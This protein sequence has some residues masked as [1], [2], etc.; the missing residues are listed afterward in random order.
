MTRPFSSAALASRN[1]HVIPCADRSRP[2][3]VT[4]MADTHAFLRDLTLVLAVAAITTV[5]FQRLRQPVVLGYLLAGMIISPNTPIPLVADLET[6]HTLAE[7][8]VI[9]LMFS[10]GLEFSFR[11]LVRMGPRA[12]FVALIQS[13]LMVW[14]GF[15]VG[16]AFGW[17]PLESLF[18]GAAIAISSTTIIVKAFQEQGVKG[19]LASVVFAVLIV[20]DLIAILLLAV[21][22]AVA[23]GA[24]VSAGSLLTTLLQLVLFLLAMLVLGYLIVPRA[25]RF[26][27]RLERSE[28]ILV[29]CIGT[30]F[31]L[32]YIAQA[33]GYSVAL[34][35]FMAGSLMAESGEEKKIEHL[36]E[37]VRDMF[38][39]IFF[40][41]VGMLID[42]RLIAEH[43]AAVLALVG[44]VIV[45]KLVGVASGAFLAGYGTRT[46][47]EAGLSLAQ[48]GEF[49][50]IIASLGVSLGVVRPFLYPVA[51]A[52]SAVTT[53]TTPWLIRAAPRIATRLDHLL[54]QPLQTFAALYASWWERFGAA[55]KP[56]TFG[57]QVRRV[58]L[59]LLVDVTCIL[60]IV[61]GASLTTERIVDFLQPLLGISSAAAHRLI[62]IGGAVLS[63][64]FLIGIFRCAR[65]LATLFSEAIFARSSGS[66]TLTGAS[67]RTLVVMIY[68]G[69]VLLIGTPLV[70]LTQPVLS[71]YQGAIL[72][73]VVVAVALV[74]FWRSARMLHAEVR[75]GAQLVIDAVEHALPSGTNDR[76]R[77]HAI[78]ALGTTS[79]LRLEPTS[80]AV[81]KTLAEL[82][83]RGRTGAM[84]VAME[85]DDQGA[86]I[87][88]PREPLRAGDVLA[89]AGT[90]DS[91]DA[92]LRLLHEGPV[93]REHSPPEAWTAG[94]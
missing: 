5:L 52:V 18:A 60:L 8:G 49:S 1:D 94:R 42:P 93:A 14:L 40:V 55:P 6:V 46:S 87:P 65:A 16:R 43:W 67:R 12:A 61:F 90:R 84:V 59:L 20:E 70:A 50:F 28:T 79:A 51:V 25:I 32:S 36:I 9:L 88:A 68:L 29:A 35:A 86:S 19:P 13:S 72:L 83:L 71:T 33:A 22:T 56:N 89:L 3:Y 37:P 30:C 45:G 77:D 57:R 66:A 31:A 82:D 7:L 17:T 78:P 48:I 27:H 85:R 24:G 44:L 39:A 75:A 41:S 47:I 15:V 92:A 23:T 81:G 54:P 64:P 53:L 62:A 91:V 34:G 76:T 21:L 58:A 73:L 26:V 74:A 80:Y 38:A 63:V 2:W 69:V 10:L 11:K 4:F